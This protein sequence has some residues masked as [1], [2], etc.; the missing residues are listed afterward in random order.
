MATTLAPSPPA[1]RAYDA[2]AFFVFGQA[3]AVAAAAMVHRHASPFYPFL[4]LASSQPPSFKHSNRRDCCGSTPTRHTRAWPS[5]VNPFSH[6]SYV[7]LCLR[8]SCDEV[9]MCSMLNSHTTAVMRSCARCSIHTR[10]TGE[11][12]RHIVCAVA[13]RRAPPSDQ[14][15][16]LSSSR[17]TTPPPL[18]RAGSKRECGVWIEWACDSCFSTCAGQLLLRNLSVRLVQTFRSYV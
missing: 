3:D 11:R 8:V 1:R 2:P 16:Q 5:A 17:C 12:D 4:L 14:H 6:T 9:V 10:P 7:S 18:S 15:C 13:I